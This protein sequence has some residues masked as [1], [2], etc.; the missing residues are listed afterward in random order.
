[1][2]T[3]QVAFPINEHRKEKTK[4]KEEEGIWR[5]KI[6]FFLLIITSS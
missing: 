2:L 1:M 6:S 4:L 3:V 5:E